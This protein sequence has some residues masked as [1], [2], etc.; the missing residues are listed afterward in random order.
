MEGAHIVL[1][2]DSIQS[3]FCKKHYRGAVSTTVYIYF[4][5]LSQRA[6]NYAHQKLQLLFSTYCN[7]ILNKKRHVIWVCP[8]QLSL[9]NF[10]CL[11]TLCS[12]V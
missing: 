5:A 12:L 11:K 3:N 1:V 6:P 4:P 7:C 10:Q 8:L 9:Y 2:Q